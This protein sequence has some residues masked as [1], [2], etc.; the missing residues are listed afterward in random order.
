M[1]QI[2]SNLKYFLYARKSSEAEDRQMASIDS[3]LDELRKISKTD[4]LDVIE[5]FTEA[6]SAKEPGRPVFNA[7][8]E[9][10]KKGEAQGIICWKINRLSRNPIDGGNVQW[11]LQN[12]SLQH[13]RTHDR[14]YYPTDNVLMM[15]V[16]LGIANQFVR[17]LS[18]DTKRGLKA[19]AEKGWLPG[20]APVG[21]LNTRYKEKGSRDIIKDPERFP[22]IKKIWELFVTGDYSIQ[23]LWGIATVDFGLVMIGGRSISLSKMYEI[24][25]NPFYYGEFDYKGMRYKGKHEPMISETDFWR[26]QEI[27]G[28]KHKARPHNKTF[29]FTGL[30]RCGECGGTITAETKVKRPKNGKIHEYTY[31]RCTKKKHPECSQGC[32]EEKE[33]TKQLIKEIESLEI[34]PE[35]HK[36]A[37][38]MVRAEYATD[39]ETRNIILANNQKAYGECTAKL[40]KLIDMRA[41][42]EIT[43]EE[44]DTKKLALMKEKARISELI[45]D[46]DGSIEKQIANAEE[47]LDFARDARKK[48]TNGLLEEKRSVLAHFGSNPV[49]LNKKVFID[50]EKPLLKIREAASEAKRITERLEPIES[51][52]KQ[53]DLEQMYALNPVL[54]A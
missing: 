32:L 11:L 33:L 9:R 16:E 7:M 13:I 42:E 40:D 30:M 37:I 43:R 17:D 54:G 23:K 45:N 49:I 50:I 14:S 3:Q 48:L 28:N 34:P 39:A 51:V 21:Y 2:N 38:E 6:K 1:K 4:G 44:Y 19:K 29:A 5:E 18:T 12:G 20:R 15:S 27:M 36:W 53:K 35:F 22:I 10:I 31:Y 8:L 26:A 41:A 46:T 24:F 52:E 47:A 25:N